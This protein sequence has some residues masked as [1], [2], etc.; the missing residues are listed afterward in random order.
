MSSLRRTIERNK[1]K[2]LADL[3]KKYENRKV[4]K[5][6]DKPI[7]LKANRYDIR[8]ILALAFKG[9]VTLLKVKDKVVIKDNR[10]E[11]QKQK[12]AV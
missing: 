7:E 10:K 2:R 12:K 1:I 3:Y 5:K 4:K 6:K 9:K 11:E 8:N